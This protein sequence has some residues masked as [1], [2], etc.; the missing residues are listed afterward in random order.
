MSDAMMPFS[1]RE[2]WNRETIY[3]NGG[4]PE[5]KSVV[6]VKVS[7]SGNVFFESY[8]IGPRGG[9]MPAG[10]PVFKKDEWNEIV[11]AVASEHDVLAAMAA[12]AAGRGR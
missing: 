5:G 12:N 3:W 9:F 1:L 7:G 10:Y 11:L 8:V 4:K 2:V 6:K